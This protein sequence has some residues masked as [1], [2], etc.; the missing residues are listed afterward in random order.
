MKRVCTTHLWRLSHPSRRRLPSV[1]ICGHCV[2]STCDMARLTR[3]GKLEWSVSGTE[4]CPEGFHPHMDDI[5]YARTATALDRRRSANVLLH[6]PR[7]RQSSGWGE[8]HAQRWRDLGPGRRIGLR[9]VG[10]LPIAGTARSRA[11]GKNCGGEGALRRGGSAAQESN[12]DAPGAG[13]AHRY[14]TARPHDVPESRPDDWGA[15]GRGGAAT[16]ASTRCHTARQGLGGADTAA[17]PG[18]G[19]TTPALS[20]SAQR[21]DAAAGEQ[22]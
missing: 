3:Q 12:G 7:G 22:R 6:P 13:E 8:F 19:R 20:T 1:D 18:R 5:A 4:R 17:H 16:P 15:G 11:G 10:D 21:R 2:H 14:G 9:E